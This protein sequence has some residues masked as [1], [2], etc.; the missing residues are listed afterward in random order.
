MKGE[1]RSKRRGAS[2][3]FAD[4][5]NYVV[6][7]DLRFVDWNIFIR[8]DRLFIKLFEEEEDLH[9]HLLIDTS[10]S[11]DFGEPSKLHYAKQVSAA[12]SFIGLVNHD[13]VV[14]STYRDEL[15]DCMPAARG[16][17]SY[18]RVTEFLTRL[19][20]DEGSHLA[21][22]CKSFAIRQPGKGV[23]VLLSDLLDKNGFEEGL[24]YLIAKQYDIYVI[25]VL[26]GEEVEPELVGDL[27]LVDSEDGDVAE[28]TVSAPLLKRYRANVDAY[29]AT[30]KDFC[31]RRGITYLFT[32]NQ[33]PF[34]HLILNYLRQRGLVK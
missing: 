3:E 31:S 21:K 27:R 12:L 19:T 14:I 10:R 9:F 13:R 30:V 7:D 17:H 23:V 33:I 6:G 4:H 26:A 20:A 28:I 34:E 5:R 2:I 1:R 8:L 16:R 32:T 24:R 25:H 15:A 11:M 22:S 29:C 18:W